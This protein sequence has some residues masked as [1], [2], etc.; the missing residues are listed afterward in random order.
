MSNK[1]KD[2]F[3]YLWISIKII[4]KKD[5]Y[6]LLRNV[7]KNLQIKLILEIKS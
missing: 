7:L 5:V 2:I 6:L 3:P 4:N 1:I